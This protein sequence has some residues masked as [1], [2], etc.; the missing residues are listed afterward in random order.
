[1]DD[2]F[3]RYNPQN[4]SLTTMPSTTV[5]VFHHPNNTRPGVNQLFNDTSETDFN[6]SPTS[7]N[8]TVINIHPGSLTSPFI[9]ANSSMNSTET[10][11]APLLSETIQRF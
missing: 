3:E 5:R 2:P 11:V 10:S 9:T 7:A 4:I 6:Y 8:T 1:M